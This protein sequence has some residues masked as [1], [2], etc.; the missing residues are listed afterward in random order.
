MIPKIL[1]TCNPSKNWTYTQYYRP[2]KENKIEPHKK[3]IQS[4]VD[5]N[6]FISKHYKGQLEKLDEVSK[7]RLLFG[8]WE[9]NA[10]EDNLCN[11][12]SIINLFTQKGIEGDKYITCDVARF[13]VDKT[14]IMYWEGL[15][16]KKILSFNK[17]SVTEV[18]EEIKKIQQTEGVNLRNI[19]VDSDGVGGGVQDILRCKGF[20]NNGRPIKKENYQNI[21]TQCYYKLADMINKAQIGI[22]TND[23]TQ[24]NNIIEELEQIRSKDIDKDNKLQIL[25]K[26]IVKTIIGRSPD[27]SD[28]MMMR[29][30]Y[31]VD[32]NFGKYYVQ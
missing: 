22:E 10:G 8:N 2:A 20:Q 16:I 21:K 18:G 7:Q 1:L 23:I 4:L 32:A 31:E 9:Y 13:G 12:D 17:S 29:M 15:C 11:Y 24:K 30:F 14:V 27:Y 25:P 5:D 19:I 26:E 28:A 3:F 6:P